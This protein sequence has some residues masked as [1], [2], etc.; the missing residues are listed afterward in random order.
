M[1]LRNTSQFRVEDVDVNAVDADTL[2]AIAE[3]YGFPELPI[4]Y[5]DY[6]KHL[7]I[8]GTREAWE[9]AVRYLEHE[10]PLGTDMLKYAYLKLYDW[11]AGLEKD[12]LTRP[13]IVSRMFNDRNYLVLDKANRQFARNQNLNPC[14]YYRVCV[15][16]TQAEARNFPELA[17]PE[18]NYTIRGDMESWL[19]AAEVFFSS[20]VVVWIIQKLIE[21]DANGNPLAPTNNIRPRFAGFTTT[22]IHITGG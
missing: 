13:S 14:H 10:K 11:F 5:P 1:A 4:W 6:S 7:E 8:A 15:M 16:L 9:Q 22:E 21:L 17:I 20:P 19:T 18:Y 2:F 12:P 3:H